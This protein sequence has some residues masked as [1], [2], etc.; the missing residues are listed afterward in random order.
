MRIAVFE[1]G[2]PPVSLRDAHG[3]YP[4]MFA[5]LLGPDFTVVR[6]DVEEEP[7]PASV[8][9]FEG[10]LIT[11]SA[12]GVYEDHAFIEPLSDFLRKAR[13]VRPIIGVCFGHQLLAQ[14]YGGRVEKSDKG[15]GVGLHAYRVR[16][17]HDF[18]DEAETVA[19]PA[20]H[21]DQVVEPPPGARV[22]LESDFAPYAGLVYDDGA[23]ISF[24]PH[25]EF[26]PDYAAALIALRRG[27]A[28]SEDVADR[29]LESLKAPNDRDRLAGWMRA[30][31]LARRP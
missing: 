10:Y 9:D 12:H 4:T 30:Y 13:G 28:L 6:V 23:A 15:W 1:T 2:K 24:Q 18:M 27:K 16:E 7:L 14:A 3:D 22:I 21:Q 31:F 26:H 20:S 5:R 25:P 19:I 17:A 11:G 8:E 29:G